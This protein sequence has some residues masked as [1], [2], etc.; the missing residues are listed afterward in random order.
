MTKDKDVKMPNNIN[1]LLN[2]DSKSAILQRKEGKNSLSWIENFGLHLFE[3]DCKPHVSFQDGE[4]MI[5]V[6]RIKKTENPTRINTIS[7]YLCFFKTKDRYT[8]FCV[9]AACDEVVEGLKD[10]MVDKAKWTDES[11]KNWWKEVFRDLKYPI[12]EDT[13]RRKEVLASD[14][15]K[16]NMMDFIEKIQEIIEK[17][18]S[19]L[20]V[21]KQKISKVCIVEQYAMAL[22]FRYAINRMFPNAKGEVY[23]FVWKEKKMSWLQHASRFQVPG[24]L[25]HTTMLTSSQISIGDLLK[26]EE[27]G[28]IITLPL[29][30]GENEDYSVPSST[31]I[32]NSDLKWNELLTENVTPDY[33]VENIAFKRLIL[34]MFSDGFQR[35]YVRCGTNVVA[36]SKFEKNKYTIG[37]VSSQ[38]LEETNEIVS[39]PMQTKEEDSI[40]Q[41]NI[42]SGASTNSG[43]RI[44]STTNQTSIKETVY[45][46][47]TNVFLD[48]P[49]ILDKIPS[50]CKIGLTPKI[51]DE[52]DGNKKKSEDLKRK[53]TQAQ[54]NIYSKS[55]NGNQIVYKE[56]NLKLLHGLNG[57]NPDNKILALAL[58]LKKE[59]F[60][61][62]L[63]TSDWGLLTSASLN[64]VNT[65]EL[66]ELLNK[67]K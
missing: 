52:I 56:P 41:T 28:V 45:V 23:P 61:P 65:L 5:L 44:T 38:N 22:P 47:D 64:K 25:L 40:H 6:L 24:K 43:H 31:V 29:S 33:I 2:E 50:N 11:T 58:T 36:C 34:S 1:I 60:E 37:R 26:L 16:M 13:L 30:K 9:N 51:I 12:D 14:S 10:L 46:I 55:K 19:K 49:N 32:E 67:K 3:E 66:N 54:K 4:N 20:N 21:D 53:A 8:R 35:I 18:I 42:R 48:C 63:L 39:D 17:A 15:L 7:T 59:G 27:N 62:I 57:A